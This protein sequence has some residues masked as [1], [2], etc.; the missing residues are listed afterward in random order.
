MQYNELGISGIKIPSIIFGTSCL[1]NLY[2]PL[3]KQIKCAIVNEY[4]NQLEI[5]VLDSA[6]KYGAGLAL[7]VI[8]EC[9]QALNIKSEH[10]IISNKLGWLRTP[11]KTAEPTFEPGVWK[12]LKFDAKQSISYNGI[13]ECWEQGRELLGTDYIPQMVSVHDPDEYL[14]LAHSGNERKKRFADILEAY[15][16]LAEL[17]KK[18]FAKAVGVGAKNWKIIREI[19]AELELDWIMFA[20]SYTIFSH[21]QELL[22]YMKKLDQR[23]I[24]II[25]SAVFHSGFLT[26]SNYFD[27]KKAEEDDP[28]YKNVYSWRE[29]F[30]ML[31]KQ[32]DV[33]AAD[34]CIQFAL[35]PKEVTS[36]SLNTSKPDRVKQNIDSITT[37]IA[38][39][40]WVALKSAGL[41]SKDYPYLG[42]SL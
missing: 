1:G 30:F 33:S 11:L 19:E 7:E 17:K 29:K 37:I 16:A 42:F 39:E 5:P 31:C 13:I 28:D 21:P 10:I 40:F 24:G 2:Q 9:L 27:Y 14:A 18:G 20:N 26:G 22:E 32:Y 6:G 23:N 3:P 8:G 41:I 38:D 15:R 34:A 4:F 36:I 25:N 12:D 35:S